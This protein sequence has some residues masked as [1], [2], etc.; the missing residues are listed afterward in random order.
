MFQS[1]DSVGVSEPRIF[2]DHI[3]GRFSD[4]PIHLRQDTEK[5]LKVHLE[6][7]FHRLRN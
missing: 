1:K 4:K 6:Q 3:G 7:R 5:K 2:V